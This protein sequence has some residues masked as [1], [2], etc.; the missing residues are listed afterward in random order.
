M[1]FYLSTSF[2]LLFNFQQASQRI[3]PA[4]GVLERKRERQSSFFDS[5]VNRNDFLRVSVFDSLSWFL[6]TTYS[7]EYIV[8]ASFPVYLSDL[9]GYR[10]GRKKIFGNE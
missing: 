6:S 7:T 3:Q 2:A 5:N 9:M 8:V 1:E 10:T 4:R